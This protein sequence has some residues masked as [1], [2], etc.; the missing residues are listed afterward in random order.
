MPPTVMQQCTDAAS[1]AHAHRQG[2][3]FNSVCSQGETQRQGN[4]ITAR[5]VCRLGTVT[6]TS[7]SVTT[8]DFS[9]TYK[10]VVNSRYEPPMMGRSTDS[11]TVEARWLGP[12]PPGHRPGEVRTLPVPR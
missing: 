4:T 6:V 11:S 7:Q 10:V 12:C 9:S 3:E 1:E 8:G 5:S 2:G